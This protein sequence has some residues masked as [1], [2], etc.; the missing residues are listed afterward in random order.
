LLVVIEGVT[1]EIGMESAIDLES[2]SREF[3]LVEP[4]R[5]V[6]EFISQHP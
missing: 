6:R 5:Q 1:A 3:Q 2:L 4:A